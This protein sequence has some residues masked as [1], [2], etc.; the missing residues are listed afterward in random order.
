MRDLLDEPA[1]AWKAERLQTVE[2]GWVADLLE[3]QGREGDWPKGRWTDSVWTLLLLVASGRPEGHPSAS[4]P[5]ERLLGAGAAHPAKPQRRVRPV[6][7]S[8]EASTHS[9]GQSSRAA[10]VNIAAPSASGAS[11]THQPIRRA[12]AQTACQFALAFHQSHHTGQVIHDEAAAHA[13][14]ESEPP[15][16]TIPHI[17]VSIGIRASVR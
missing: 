12:R 3:R 11:Q 2:T 13:S 7:R 10:T 5:V 6:A 9:L 14:I 1:E 15:S 16:T 4:L 8:R 17:V